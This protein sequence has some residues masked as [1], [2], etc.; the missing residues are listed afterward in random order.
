MLCLEK[1]P[2]SNS[3][4]IKIVKD[5]SNLSIDSSYY[6]KLYTGSCHEGKLFAA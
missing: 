4:W 6:T 3:K 2:E 1:E 5:T